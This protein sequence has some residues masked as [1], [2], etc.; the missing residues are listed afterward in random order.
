MTGVTPEPA[1]YLTV[2]GTG[3]TPL[4]GA[5]QLQTASVGGTEPPPLPTCPADS[6]KSGSLCVDKYEGSLWDIPPAQTVLIQKVQ[7][8]TATLADLTGGGATQVGT[9]SAPFNHAAIPVT[10]PSDGNYTAPIYA[11]SIFGVLPSTSV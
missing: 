11:V 5:C 1:F 7:D 10:C 4:G 9:T 6:A 3:V 2:T 8:G